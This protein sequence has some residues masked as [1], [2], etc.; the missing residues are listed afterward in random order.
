V[1]FRNV[2]DNAAHVVIIL[3][4]GGASYGCHVDSQWAAIMDYKNL[5][6]ELQRSY[7]QALDLARYSTSWSQFIRVLRYCQRLER[8]LRDMG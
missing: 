1:R 6:T 7:Q 5:K 3:I 4:P 8:A 2:R